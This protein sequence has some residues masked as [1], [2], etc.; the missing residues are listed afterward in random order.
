MVVGS[1]IVSAAAGRFT[2]E[3]VKELSNPAG[4]PA[5]PS[6]SLQYTGFTGDLL[7]SDDEDSLDDCFHALLRRG[8]DPFVPCWGLSFHRYNL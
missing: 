4:S 1:G 5:K 6:F 8:S 3:L 2:D 7:N